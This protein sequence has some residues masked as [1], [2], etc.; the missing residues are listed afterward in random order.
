M[1]MTTEQGAGDARAAGSAAAGRAGVDGQIRGWIR[2]HF[3]FLALAIPAALLV[4]CFFLAPLIN[5]LLLSV[6]EPSIGLANYKLLLTSEGI[7]R[8]VLRTLRL[9]A[10][11]T[12]FSR[13]WIREKRGTRSGKPEMAPRP[14]RTP[15]ARRQRQR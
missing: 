10:I 8:I 9:C 12:V 11:T 5:V 2:A 7:Q 3:E 13:F 1:S 6:T 15:M 4:I 14:R